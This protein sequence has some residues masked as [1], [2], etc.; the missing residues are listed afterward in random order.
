MMSR[1]AVELRAFALV[2]SAWGWV[3]E[4]GWYVLGTVIASALVGLSGYLFD[5]LP[6]EL[7]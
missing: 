4:N 5:Q 1:S 3:E 7:F 6:D 2:S